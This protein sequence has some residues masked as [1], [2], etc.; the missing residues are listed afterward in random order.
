[1]LY[2]LIDLL[3]M[4]S[5]TALMTVGLNWQYGY[6]GILNFTYYTFVGVGAYVAAVTTMGNPQGLGSQTYIL[7]WSLPWP[8]GLLLAGLASAALGLLMILVTV[9]RLRSDYL[10]IV[11][12][13]LG[14]ILWNLIN[15]YQPLFDGGNGLF[16]IPYIT[17]GA[18]LSSVDYSIEIAV[19]GFALLGVAMWASRR[20]ER[21]PY[22][23]VLRAIREDEVVAQSFAKS[24]RGA[25]ISIFVLGSFIA[26]VSGGIVAFYLTS[27]NP[28]GFLP[29]ES[30]ILMSALIIGG[31]GSYWGAVVGAFVIIELLT[32][33]SRY[34]PSFGN[35]AAIGAVRAIV[36]GV[37]LILFMMFRPEGIVPERSYNWYRNV[38]GGP[39]PRVAGRN[40]WK[41]SLAWL[42]SRRVPQA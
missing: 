34:L 19:L 39:T 10:A 7:H 29:V 25:T 28:Q 21:S 35:G 12:V 1:M 38:T 23:R 42:N 33:I 2:F 16:G 20:I 13:S 31:T 41:G 11:T 5:V 36:I 15:D 27:W 6:A 32:E 18:T 37:S 9:R 14:Y 26:G 4:G 40:R 22:G 17:G 30:F 24:V 3:A 8:V